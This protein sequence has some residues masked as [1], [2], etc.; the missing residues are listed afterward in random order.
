[1]YF[2]KTTGETVYHNRNSV[3][4]TPEKQKHS[5]KFGTEI[6]KSKNK[7]TK[8]KNSTI[9]TQRLLPIKPKLFTAMAN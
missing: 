2:Q 3:D 6:R 9:L 4:K 8:K 5:S 1:M 7:Q